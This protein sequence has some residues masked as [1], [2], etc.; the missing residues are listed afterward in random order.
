MDYIF[1]LSLLIRL[2]VLYITVSYDIACQWSIKFWERLKIYPDYLQL[3]PALYIIR[4]LIPKFHLPAHIL[5]CQIIYSLNYNKDCARTDGEGLERGWDYINP[6]ATSTREMGPGSRRDTLDAHFGDWN[7]RKTCS[8][9]KIY[10]PPSYLWVLIY[11]QATFL[12][13]QV[14]EAVLELEEK[15]RLHDKF[16]HGLPAEDVNEWTAML[17]AW[18][19]DHSRPNPLEVTM[20]GWFISSESSLGRI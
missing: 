6:I 5:L 4:F 15:S 7:W 8:M 11:F 3:L 9:G 12:L 18:E 19:D 2:T 20:K 1:L 14:K 10:L 17:D 16:T 13:R